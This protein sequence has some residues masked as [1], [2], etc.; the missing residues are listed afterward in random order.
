MEYFSSGKRL[1]AAR[2][3]KRV[4]LKDLADAFNVGYPTIQKWQDRGIPDSAI[5]AVA[6]YFKVKKWVFCD[7][8]LSEKDFKEII[9]HPILMDKFQAIFIFKGEPEFA[10]QAQPFKS[11]LFFIS[12]KS[13]LL[14]GKVWGVKG[15]SYTYFLIVEKDKS[16]RDYGIKGSA[17][18]PP[19]PNTVHLR[20]AFMF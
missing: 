19:N 3:I 4:R 8:T 14:R 16:T 5:E 11:D 13:V 15:V 9:K 12:T 18:L 10:N 20:V 7:E 17:H 2:N 6:D 1:Q